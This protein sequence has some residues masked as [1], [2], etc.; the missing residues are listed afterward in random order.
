MKNRYIYTIFF[1]F[2]LYSK[3]WNIQMIKENLWSSVLQESSK[4]TKYPVGSVLFVGDAN[5]GRTSLIN[6]LC[7]GV[8]GIG[9]KNL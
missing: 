5:C 2:C 9:T 3:R 7:E 1:D 4:R 6:K 8:D